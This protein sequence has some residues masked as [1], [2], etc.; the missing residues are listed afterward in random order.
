MTDR[1]ANQISDWNG[2]V[3]QRWAAEQETLDAL[4][5]PFGEAVLTAAKPAPGEKVLDIGC[6]CGETSLALGRAVGPSGQVLGVDV[7]APMLDV[8]RRRAAGVAN[9]TFAQADASQARLPEGFSLLASRFGVMFFD[10]PADAF[11]RMG[12]ALAPGA[13]LAFVC[14]QAAAQNPWAT[15]AARAALAAAGLPSPQTDPRAPGP[16]AFADTEYVTGILERA[17]FRSIAARPVE[18]PMRLGNTVAEAALSALRIGPASRIA[19][20]AGPDAFPKLLSAVEAVFAPLAGPAGEVALPGR[21]W[22]FT[23]NW[24]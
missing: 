16:F 10:A 2:A 23:A 5:R 9:V 19:R 8:A 6:G 1:N 21:T 24:H 11:A 3:G 17:G 7:S 12:E 4:I 20:E 13:R 22:I 18:A 14:W 15:V